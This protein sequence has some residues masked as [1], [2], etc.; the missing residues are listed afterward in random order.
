MHKHVQE[1]KEKD[2]NIE[3]EVAGILVDE[4]TFVAK[5]DLTLDKAVELYKENNSFCWIECFV[6]DVEKDSLKIINEFVKMSED[7]YKLLFQHNES[8][9]QDYENSVGLKFTVVTMTD[10]I[11][12]P[13]NYLIL[14]SDRLILTIHCAEKPVTKVFDIS[15][16]L[17]PRILAFTY[18]HSKQQ[19]LIDAQSILLVRIIDD[20]TTVNFHTLQQIE[21]KAEKLE[22]EL[23]GL[24]DDEVFDRIVEI[25][26]DLSKFHDAMW[27]IYDSIYQLRH[28]D[29]NLIT[30]EKDYLEEFN[31]LLN[32]ISNQIQSS[33][34][35]L[36]LVS[37][38]FTYMQSRNTNDLSKLIVVLTIVGTVVLVPNT[39][40]TVFGAITI[41]DTVKI[42]LMVIL[43][44]I[45]GFW[46]YRYGKLWKRKRKLDHHSSNNL[47]KIDSR[48]S[49]LKV[50]NKGTY[51]YE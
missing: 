1:L 37:T 8:D 51:S 30:D 42:S 35:V 15:H 21:K 6:K 47:P 31:H 29:A 41:P 4:K 18:T 38:G 5:K 24:S 9:Y 40:G 32:L 39:I 45:S 36:Q 28:G 26:N 27:S 11:I 7:E 20:I 12:K 48:K 25:K 50:D 10:N 33:S 2:S 16:R 22:S 43:T 34:N 3:K 13:T 14:L 19:F 17:L 49:N 23:R 46:S 44:G